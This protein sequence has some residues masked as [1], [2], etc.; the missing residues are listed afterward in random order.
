M[1][2]PP[3]REAATN[4]EEL[5]DTKLKQ[6]ADLWTDA[7]KN[8]AS[9]KSVE[10]NPIVQVEEPDDSEAA[11]EAPVS[12]PEKEQ[13]KGFSIFNVAKKIFSAAQSSVKR[14]NDQMPEIYY[15][16]SDDNP[17]IRMR[18]KRSQNTGDED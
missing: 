15:K 2:L 10:L 6:E 16:A 9:G 17:W 3:V 7:A 18:E 1:S 5:R 8:I 14:E 12:N 4:L 11:E 13:K